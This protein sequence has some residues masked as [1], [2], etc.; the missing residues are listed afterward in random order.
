MTALREARSGAISQGTS[1]A[2][3]MDV[4]RGDYRTGAGAAHRLPAGVTLSLVTTDD[5][6]QDGMHGTI[7][8]FPDGSSSGGRLHLMRGD[9]GL[10]TL[11]DWLTG[12]VSL[13]EDAR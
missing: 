8:F 6:R 12:R 4:A 9:R 5:N 10:T 1:T 7:R 11:V 2:F 13:E 3:R